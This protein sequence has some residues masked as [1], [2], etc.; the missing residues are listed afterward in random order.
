M[1][2][3]GLT[4]HSETPCWAPAHYLSPPSGTQTSPSRP[5]REGRGLRAADP[6]LLASLLGPLPSPPLEPRPPSA[7]PAHHQ[8]GA[9]VPGSGNESRFSAARLVLCSPLAGAADLPE[10]AT[11]SCTVSPT[12]GSVPVPDDVP[13][14]HTHVCVRP[15]THARAHTQ[16]TS[17]AFFLPCGPPSV[18]APRLCRHSDP[19]KTPVGAEYRPLAEGSRSAAADKLLYRPLAL[20]TDPPGGLSTSMRRPPPD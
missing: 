6:S 4:W 3:P 20:L 17:S 2:C 9:P 18:S 16:H 1:S 12:K 7:S 14:L 15:H 11:R 10:L 19:A 13:S 5:V 8:R